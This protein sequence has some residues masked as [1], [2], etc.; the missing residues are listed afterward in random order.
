MIAI[1]A[2]MA[3]TLSPD[4]I[5]AERALRLFISGNSASSQRA[6]ANLAR[7][8]SVLQLG[9]WLIEIIDVLEAPHRAEEAGILAT[10]TLLRAGE[11]RARRI[12]G[13]LSDP[14]RVLAFLEIEPRSDGT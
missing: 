12:V 10:P 6:R 9:D 4:P 7:L 8:E 11:A 3:R 2:P 13:D 14:D 5:M 1:A